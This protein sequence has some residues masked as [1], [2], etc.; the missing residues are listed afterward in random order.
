MEELRAAST[1]YP[2]TIR[3][4]YLQL[5]ESVPERVRLLAAQL[6]KEERTAYD[7]AR[8]IEAYLRSYPYDL[9]VPEPPD[10][11]DVADYFLFDLKKGYCDYYATAMVV[12]ARASG[13]PARF[14]SGYAPGSYD[15]ERARYIVRELNAHSWAE[16]YFP[17]IG[18]IEFEP[19]AAQPEIERPPAMDEVGSARP[20]DTASRLLTRF[21]LQQAVYWVS[22]AA[23]VLLSLV[24]YY[25]WIERWLYL[26]RGPAAAVEAIYRRLYR[27]G[28]PLVGGRA[29]AETACEF[30]ERLL[31]SLSRIASPPRLVSYLSAAQHEVR[32]LTDLYQDALFADRILQR[33]DAR[34]ALHAWRRLRLRLLFARLAA[35]LDRVNVRR[36]M[37]I[38]GT[39]QDVSAAYERFP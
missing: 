16:V 17:G 10:D 26:R 13:L 7:K 28:R 38:D 37:R 1:D 29:R 19:T 22:P 3:A 5:P 36:L 21:R 8:S 11:R 39:Q 9:D 15:A 6:T 24:L 35:F 31:G 34:T 30:M 12:L 33:R 27:L 2:D 4:R 32:L 14:V 23:I 18:W 20:D 25:I